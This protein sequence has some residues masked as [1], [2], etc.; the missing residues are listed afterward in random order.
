MADFEDRVERSLD[1]L[2]EKIDHIGE[3]VASQAV[4]LGQ[5]NVIL[6][7]HQRRTIANENQVAVLTEALHLQRESLKKEFNEDF[8]SKLKS[9]GIIVVI[10][11][12]II[13]GVNKSG[14]LDLITGLLGG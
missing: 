1:K 14:I 13:T 5:Q 9:V 6:E 7:E 10:T 3:T 4:Q 2:H 8:R 12:A 11:G